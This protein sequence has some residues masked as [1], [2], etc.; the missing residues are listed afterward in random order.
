MEMKDS[1]RWSKTVGRLGRHRSDRRASAGETQGSEAERRTDAVLSRLPRETWSVL[2][3]GTLVG[4]GAADHVVVGPGGVY[5]IASHQPGGCVRVKDGVAWLRHGDDPRAD[6]PSVA[7]QRKVVSPARQLHRELRDLGRDCPPVHAVVVV[8]S[9]FPQRVAETNQVAYVHGR[10][11]A[12]WLQARAEELE[13]GTR[14]RVVAAVTQAVGEP[15][16]R[17]SRIS[18]RHAA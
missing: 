3:A 6:R 8:W 1:P 18:R 14:G 13:A 10:N 7:L 12:A 11:L 9:E 17:A 16:R 4:H 15:Q 5:L 2:G